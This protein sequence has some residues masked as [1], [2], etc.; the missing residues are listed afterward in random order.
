MTPIGFEDDATVKALLELLDID[1][2]LRELNWWDHAYAYR[3]Q[4]DE[5]DEFHETYGLYFICE[6]QPVILIGDEV[7]IQSTIYCDHGFGELPYIDLWI[8]TPIE[9]NS[10]FVIYCY[11]KKVLEDEDDHPNTK[12]Y[13]RNQPYTLNIGYHSKDGIYNEE[14]WAKIKSALAFLKLQKG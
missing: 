5:E 8:T 14:F 2:K 13:H 12:T 3:D 10:L 11:G 7:R 1:N 4:Y 9:K 6:V